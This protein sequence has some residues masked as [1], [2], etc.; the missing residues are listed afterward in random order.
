MQYALPEWNKKC[1]N[2]ICR[3]SREIKHIIFQYEYLSILGE[4]QFEK[5]ADL[6]AE[7]LSRNGVNDISNLT[8]D[9]AYAL[10]IMPLAKILEAAMDCAVQRV[11]AQNPSPREGEDRKTCPQ[12][13]CEPVKP[14]VETKESAE[15]ITEKQLEKVEE[16]YYDDDVD[17]DDLD[18]DDL[19]DDSGINMDLFKSFG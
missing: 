12:Y 19:D 18:D 14:P 13:S 16:P 17:D 8:A 11:L 15:T 2:L 9:E 10:E 7:L 1:G 6:V 3:K 4:R 5:I